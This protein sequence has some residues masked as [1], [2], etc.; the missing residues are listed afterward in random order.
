MVTVSFS[1]PH[2]M[3]CS[4]VLI[5]LFHLHA[6]PLVN[7]SSVSS[8]LEFLFPFLVEYIARIIQVYL[9]HH[10]YNNII[11]LLYVLV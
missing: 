2:L 9:G 10:L 1:I 8:Y 3:I 4:P 6:D 7:Q 11:M 5:T